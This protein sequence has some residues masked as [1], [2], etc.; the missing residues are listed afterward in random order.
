M[1]RMVSSGRRTAWY[2]VCPECEG[3]IRFDYANVVLPDGR[4]QF[5]ASMIGAGL[6]LHLIYGCPARPR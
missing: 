2:T 4:R 1:S 3:S 6:R 5:R